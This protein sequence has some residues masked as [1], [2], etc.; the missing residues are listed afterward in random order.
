MTEQLFQYAVLRYVHDPV[1][2]EF[3]NI[4]VLLFAPEEAQIG[5]LLNTRYS[6]LS[7]TFQQV[8][9]P[10]IRAQ[11]SALERMVGALRLRWQQGNWLERPKSVHELTSMLLPPDD[12]SL[13]FGGFGGGL[14]TDLDAELRRLY[15]RLVMRYADREDAASRDDAE[16]WQVFH[17]EL[18]QREVTL[19]LAPV[20]IRTDTFSLDFQHA[21]KNERWHPLEPISF[22]LVH[23]SS[24]LNKASKWV[25]HTLS[26]K[27]SED[28]GTIYFLLGSPR[29]EHLLRPYENALTNMRKLMPPNAE[30]IREEEAAEFSERLAREIE[31]H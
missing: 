26:L 16:V 29:Q 20:T 10:Y 3:V 11:L 14:T 31:S 21:W 23:E 28:L 5:C 17:K 19:H 8:D 12:S 9:G 18:A 4:G 27:E 24:I 2:Q 15:M 30:L 22:D 6:R 13:V 7:N 25:G 1:T